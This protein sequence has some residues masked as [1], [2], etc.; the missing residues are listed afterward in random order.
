MGTVSLSHKWPKNRK[1]QGQY[2]AKAF[3]YLGYERLYRTFVFDL[4]EGQAKIDYLNRNKSCPI[5]RDLVG[6]EHVRGLV[7]GE[8]DARGP[9][10]EG[11]HS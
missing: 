4:R 2:L 1:S 8:Q 7:I 11:R 10:L 5:Y 3:F 6:V 9:V